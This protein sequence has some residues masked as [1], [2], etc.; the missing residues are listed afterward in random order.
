MHGSVLNFSINLTVRVLPGALGTIL[1]LAKHVTQ[2]VR[3][4]PF[5]DI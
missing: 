3:G 1:L 2:K 5:S 4:S